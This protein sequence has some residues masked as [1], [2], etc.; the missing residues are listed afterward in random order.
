MT[1]CRTLLMIAALSLL[2]PLVGMFPVAASAAPLA[3][4]GLTSTPGVTVNGAGEASVP[5]ETA[6]IQLLIAHGDLFDDAM[7][8]SMVMIE[9]VPEATPLAGATDS[10]A[11]MGDIPAGVTVEQLAPI[12]EAVAQAAGV[13][14][15]DVHVTLSPL[16]SEIF[17]GQSGVARLD[18]EVERPH[19]EVVDRLMVAATEAAA[20]HG[21][22]IMSGGVFYQVADCGPVEEAAQQAALAD[23]RK[24]AERLAGL[25]G[26]TLGEVVT[27]SS[28][29]YSIP[30][31]EEACL[32]QNIPYLDSGYGGLSLTVPPYNPSLPAEVEVYS[33]LTVSYEIVIR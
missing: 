6:T 22:M 1:K 21:L 3:Q 25:L 12:I 19:A 15:E 28:G 27:A 18:L 2:T 20:A 5:A 29:D 8:G 16:P 11:A 33:N 14:P 31:V 7:G 24:R 26:A 32:G 9:P 17:F 4:V 13:T 10:Q 23:A 30:G